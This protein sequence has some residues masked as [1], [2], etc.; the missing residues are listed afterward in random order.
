MLI[1]KKQEE[2]PIA[3]IQAA[4]VDAMQAEGFLHEG[5]VNLRI[6]PP[7]TRDV[8]DAPQ[9]T[10]GDPRRPTTTPGDVGTRRTGER[11]TEQG[12]SAHHNPLEVQLSIELKPL[13]Q[14][15]PIPQRRTEGAGTGRCSH[16]S[17]RR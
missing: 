6:G 8:A 13:N 9:Q 3:G 15:E 16:Q 1:D 11:N 5:R 14:S 2:P 4:V 17:E 12:R 10:I 7:H